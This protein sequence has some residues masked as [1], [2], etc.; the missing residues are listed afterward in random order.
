MDIYA[1][2]FID[3]FGRH[4]FASNNA[5]VTSFSIL[6]PVIRF[7]VLIRLHQKNP[8]NI[9]IIDKMYLVILKAFDKS[10]AL[11]SIEL[12]K[13]NLEHMPV[14]TPEAGWNIVYKYGYEKFKVIESTGPPNMYVLCKE[15][16][17]NVSETLEKRGLLYENFEE[18]LGLYENKGTVEGN[19]D[20]VIEF[21]SLMEFIYLGRKKVEN[22]KLNELNTYTT[23]VFKW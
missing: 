15:R 1:F 10:T 14:M 17:S 2:L 5:I 7:K 13:M 9:M 22:K 11:N 16:I 8:E 12:N 18:A 4:Q 19:S 23:A 3:F 20:D 6:P 21:N